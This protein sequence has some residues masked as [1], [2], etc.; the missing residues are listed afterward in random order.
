MPD[1]TAEIPTELFHVRFI[2]LMGGERVLGDNS[3]HPA[4][5]IRR[6]LAVVV[7]LSALDGSF[8]QCTQIAC[9]DDLGS[10]ARARH[11]SQ[12]VLIG[13][14][15]S[16][17]FGVFA[18]A[19]A[20]GVERVRHGQQHERGKSLLHRER[21]IPLA[22]RGGLTPEGCALIVGFSYGKPDCDAWRR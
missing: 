14:D 18:N 8:R 13:A 22:I 4:G 20:P 12:G 6:P 11:A 10:R 7:W 17:E 5:A 19:D 9:E 1:G 2:D 16:R 21:E 15:D 3:F